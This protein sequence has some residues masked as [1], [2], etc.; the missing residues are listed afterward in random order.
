[1]IPLDR[2]L[3][4]DTAQTAAGV[5]FNRAVNLDF[6]KKGAVRG[7]PGYVRPTGGFWMTGQNNFALTNTNVANLAATG[8]LAQTPFAI[9]DKRSERPGLLT[10]GRIYSYEGDSWV[11]R[12]GAGSMRVDRVADYQFSLAG[13]LPSIYNPPAVGHDFGPGVYD[14]QTRLLS[15]EGVRDVEVA[16]PV[17]GPGTSAVSGTITATVHVAAGTNNL[18][19]TTRSAGARAITQTTIRTDAI[20]PQGFGD[21]PVICSDFGYNGFFVAYR[22]LGAHQLRVLQVSTGGTVVSANLVTYGTGTIT[23]LWMCNTAATTK[24][25]LCVVDSATTG[26]FTKIYDAGMTDQS[27]DATLFSGLQCWGPVTCGATTLLLN[28]GVFV[29]T[30]GNDGSLR[31]SKR[32]IS[33]TATTGYGSW[34]GTFYAPTGTAAT[35]G[36]AWFLQ[37]QPVWVNGRALAGVASIRAWNNVQGGSQTATWY[38]VDL[39]DLISPG[40]TAGSRRTPP[41]VARG[42]LDGSLLPWNPVAATVTADGNGLRFATIDWTRFT[43]GSPGPNPGPVT[44][45][46]IVGYDGVLGVNEVSFQTPQVDHI[47]D[48]TVIGGSI[49]RG[50]AGGAAYELGFPWLGFPACTAAVSGS[51]GSWAVGNYTVKACW[52]WIDDAGQIH[53][54]AASVAYNIA[55]SSGQK[56]T[57]FGSPY[58]FGDKNLIDPGDRGGVVIEFY[59]TSVNPTGNAAHYLVATIGGSGGNGETGSMPS[60]G[61]LGGPI[62]TT[63]TPLY[64]DVALANLPVS[65]D[66]GV[67]AVGRRCWV[68]D[69]DYLYASKLGLDGDPPNWNGDQDARSGG[70]NGFL[71]VPIPAGAGRILAL[72]RIDERVVALCERGVYVMAGDGPDDTGANTDYTA[73]L[74]VSALGVAGGVAACTT[75]RGVVFQ[76]AHPQLQESVHGGLWLIDKSLEIVQVSWPA[77]DAVDTTAA[78][79]LVFLPERA[80]VAFLA[81]AVPGQPSY[82]GGGNTGAQLTLTLPYLVMWDLHINS[83]TIW[84]APPDGLTGITSV[85]G[86]LWSAGTDVGGFTALPGIGHDTANGANTNFTME[87]QTNDMA[88]AGD[89]LGWSRVRSFRVLGD[90]ITTTHNLTMAYQQDD[91]V[92]GNTILNASKTQALAAQAQTTGWPSDRYAPEWHLPNSKCSTIQVDLQASPAVATWTYL[93]LQV[94]PERRAPAH[95]VA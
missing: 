25:V 62:D 37:H 36:H 88:A 86:Y 79:Q 53:R 46:A 70:A 29:T 71:S 48:T 83:W 17:Q 43:P 32:A 33:T 92:A 87:L 34:S 45:S 75:P 8:Y 19:L 76:A 11:D 31:V 84:T 93:E 58:Q 27:L 41:M 69:G 38:T 13:G 35:Q 57:F 56:I 63:Q 3:G 68:S 72:G 5:S 59:M 15:S 40:S 90:T 14:Q 73:P 12:F 2:G 61:A 30:L 6:G 9:T 95:Y 50:I 4:Q 74:Q 89:G 23:G 10:N 55:V 51:G 44:L 94:K 66:G 28:G 47:G 42:V 67:I 80:M 65:A 1:M 52:R 77:R 20:T 54:S 7:R 16:G 22:I 81:P 18:I 82:V 78:G 24:V 21:N 85:D 49:P 91:A 39:T 60:T 26:V 64:T